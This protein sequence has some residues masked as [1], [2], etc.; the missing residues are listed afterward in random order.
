MIPEQKDY[1]Q[2]VLVDTLERCVES[3]NISVYT[4]H[5]ENSVFITISLQHDELKGIVTCT[6]NFLLTR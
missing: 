2:K 6:V 4:V 5:N 1:I 3:D